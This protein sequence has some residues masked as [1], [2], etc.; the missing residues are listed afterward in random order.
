MAKSH[1]NPTTTFS[2]GISSSGARG[3][4]VPQDGATISNRY[5][6]REQEIIGV[7]RT[8]LEDILAFDR[9]E[10][11]SGGLGLFLFSGSFWLL[12]PELIQQWKDKDVWF[13]LTPT[14]I[15]CALLLVFGLYLLYDGHDIRRLKRGRIDRIF[16]ETK[17]RNSATPNPTPRI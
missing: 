17:P 10:L 14:V 4:V 13:S 9:R 3:S 8:D 1:E 7:N 15:I 5:L 2:P 12:V 11:R 6:N 16:N